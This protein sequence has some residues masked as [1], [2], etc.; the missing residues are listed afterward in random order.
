MSAAVQALVSGHDAALS[1]L[2]WRHI[3]LFLV[4]LTGENEVFLV[5]VRV[6]AFD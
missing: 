3:T 2:S 6:A 4:Q 5:V 1:S